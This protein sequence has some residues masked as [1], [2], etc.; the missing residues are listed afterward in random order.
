MRRAWFVI[1]LGA[2]LLIAGVAGLIIVPEHKPLDGS[3][4]PS[5]AETLNPFT[6]ASGS[7]QWSQT[8]YDV[9]RIATWAVLIVGAITLVVGLITYARGST[10]R[11][12]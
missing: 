4:Q 6:E 2:V 11:S 3:G 10:E 5:L 8:L 7:T 12:G 1:A 9:L